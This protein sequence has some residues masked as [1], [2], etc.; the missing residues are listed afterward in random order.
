MNTENQT[1]FNRLYQQYLNELTLQ[2]KSPKTIEMYNSYFRQST[3]FVDY[4]P[5]QLSSE[6]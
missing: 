2:E 3:Q 6:H 5:D 1:R 4:C